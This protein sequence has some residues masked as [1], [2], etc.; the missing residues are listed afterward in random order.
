MDKK[1]IKNICPSS[2]Q[3]WRLWLEKNHETEDAIWL[4]M[5]KKSANTPTVTWSEAVDEALCFGWI[6]S[7]KK[8][9]NAEKY[10]QYFCKRKPKSNWSKVNK[11]KIE[12]L[13]KK[14]LMFPAGI[15]SVKTAKQN[16]SW[17]IL[18]DVEALII[19]KDLELAFQQHQKAKDFFLSLSKSHRKLLL[20][21]IVSA[22]RSETR[23]KRINDIA[24][25]ME[26]HQKPS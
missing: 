23:Q 8:T 5:Y 15:E 22:K 21:K 14:G 19:P 1:E 2:K 26:N 12:M 25:Q 9:I 13:T 18:D 7:T 6:D 16:G 24:I 3:E 11:D 17:T 10:I 4:V 20:Y